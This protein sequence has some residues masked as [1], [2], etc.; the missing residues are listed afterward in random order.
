MLSLALL[1]PVTPRRRRWTIS[2][3]IRP[4]CQRWCRGERVWNKRG[5]R[6]LINQSRL[7]HV[8][9][10]CLPPSQIAVPWRLHACLPRLS[11]TR[12]AGTR[13][14]WSTPDPVCLGRAASP[15]DACYLSVGTPSPCHSFDAGSGLMWPLMWP[16]PHVCCTTT[17][18][19]ERG[20][21]PFGLY[22][23]I[24]LLPGF[25]LRWWY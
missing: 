21:L 24:F 17:T 20:F 2:R 7:L 19:H 16:I 22:P 23:S 11:K 15:Q 3:H 18:T 4:Q 25:S 10:T 9:C 6:G 14:R 8:P 1:A 12:P 13:V 5:R